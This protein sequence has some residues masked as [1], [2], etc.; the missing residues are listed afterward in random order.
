MAP[1][2]SAVSTVT[3]FLPRK[4]CRGWSRRGVRC[5]S[6]GDL[7][8]ILYKETGK[9]EKRAHS[10]NRRINKLRRINTP[11]GFD[12]LLQHHKFQLTLF[13]LPPLPAVAPQ[14]FV[15][16]RRPPGAGH[17]VG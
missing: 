3:R 15:G 5:G 7:Y 13:D 8:T 1:T 2:T 6:G 10:A 16:F 12:S 11:L 17:M 9:A 4:L 14:Q